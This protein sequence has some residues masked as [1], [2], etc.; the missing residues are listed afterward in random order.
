[1][2]DFA[3]KLQKAFER[4]LSYWRYDDQVTVKVTKIVGRIPIPASD[5]DYAKCTPRPCSIEFYKDKTFY[6]LEVIYSP[7]Y[8]KTHDTSDLATHRL[9][10]ICST[11]FVVLGLGSTVVGSVEWED[12]RLIF[13]IPGTEEVYKRLPPLIDHKG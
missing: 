3:E 2:E 10:R 4:V 1:M 13:P 5:E 11:I 8:I 12:D 9:P 7:K 6:T